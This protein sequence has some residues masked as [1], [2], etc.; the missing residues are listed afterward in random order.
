MKTG[1]IILVILATGPLC[2][3]LAAQQKPTVAIIG[4]GTLAG[5]LGPAMGDSGYTVVYGS[6]DPERGSVRT[7]V[8]RTGRKASAVSPREAAA[9]APIIILAV[10]GEVVEEV[11]GTLG[12]LAGKVVIDVSGGEK[13]VAPDGYLELVSDKTRAER[14]Q[15]SHP[16]TRVVRINLP[17]M[18]FFTDPLLIGTRPTVL[19]AGNDPQARQAAA[20]VIF[21]LGLDPWDAGPL[22]FSRVFDALNV[23]NLVPAQQGRTES[24]ELKLLPSL[25]LSCFVDVSELFGF[26]QPYDLNKLPTFPRRD[27]TVSCDEWRRRLGIT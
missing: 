6:R 25:P 13:R 17:L 2:E 27:R 20:E 10:P 26:G 19:I 11:A 1:V 9:Q 18:T 14:I 4:T 7:L 15:S 5:T 12:E 21:N 16:E 3:S 24:Y 22:R 23:M 8:E